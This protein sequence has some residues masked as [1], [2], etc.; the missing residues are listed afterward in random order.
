MTDTRADITEIVSITHVFDAPI[1]EVFKAWTDPDELA[2]WYGPASMSIRRETTHIDPRP[3]G[4]FEFTM[5]SPDGEREFS[6]GYTIVEFVPPRL[7]VLKSDPMAHGGD[8]E[9]P[10]VRVEL[11]DLGG[12]TRMILTDGP[13]PFGKDHAEAGYRAAIEKLEAALA[14]G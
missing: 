11:D 10:T 2:A 12:Q 1:E 4:R 13:M 3:G 5:A 14:N 8:G 7:L 9:P 6:L